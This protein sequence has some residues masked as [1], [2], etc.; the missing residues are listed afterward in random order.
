MRRAGV[1]TVALLALGSASCLRILFPDY[2]CE[3]S[4][5]PG[6]T[7]CGGNST[8]YCIL[9]PLFGCLVWVDDVNC[10]DRAA[11][12]IDAEC[13]CPDGAVPCPPHS[14]C[15]QLAWD[16]QNCGGCGI[17]CEGACLD[18]QCESIGGPRPQGP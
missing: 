8:Q 12:C 14:V 13:V 6:T 7:Q 3:D 11:T 16:P 4:C 18:G 15:A 1:L 10:D 5:I 17:V 2:E 9:E